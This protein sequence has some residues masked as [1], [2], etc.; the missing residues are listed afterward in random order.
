MKKKYLREETD[1]T[2]SCV[3][4][5]ERLKRTLQSERMKM[6]DDVMAMMQSDLRDL[7]ERYL[8]ES[9]E[10]SEL[11]LEVKQPSFITVPMK[12]NNS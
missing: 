1:F 5:K 8:G 4:A 9:V 6:S 10:E 2:D 7:I 11:I 3:I 12:S